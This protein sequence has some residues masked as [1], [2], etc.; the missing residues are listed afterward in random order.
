MQ[1]SRL[2]MVALCLILVGINQPVFADLQLQLENVAAA[3]RQMKHEHA[4]QH[5]KEQK[6]LRSQQLKQA[7]I[8]KRNQEYENE[9]R[10]L[11]LLDKQLELQAKRARIN[12][13]NEYIDADLAARKAQTDAIQASADSKRNISSGMKTQLEKTGE[14]ALKKASK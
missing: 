12:R 10:Q 4:K 7:Q 6:R 8:Q 13:T 11:K 2:F 5:A 1:H 14:A 3:E 9:L